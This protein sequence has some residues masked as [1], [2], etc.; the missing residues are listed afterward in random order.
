MQ[1][2]IRPMIFGIKKELFL[3]SKEKELNIINI[4]ISDYFFKYIN[5]IIEYIEEIQSKINEYSNNLW[6]VLYQN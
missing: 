5:N 4:Q 3:T 6:T 2:L 1:F